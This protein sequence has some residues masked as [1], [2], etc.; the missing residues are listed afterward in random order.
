M[1]KWPL[2]QE[3]FVS[4]EQTPKDK[5]PENGTT[6]KTLPR[7]TENSKWE[8]ERWPIHLVPRVLALVG[9]L[10]PDYKKVLGRKEA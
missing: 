10:G 1:R 6:R 7:E 4:A 2:L 5:K 3:E 8:Q 9:L